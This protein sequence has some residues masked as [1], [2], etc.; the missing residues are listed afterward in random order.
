MAYDTVDKNVKPH[1][2]GG[3]ALVS[4]GKI[5][6][7]WGTSGYDD[8]KLGRWCWSRYQGSYGRHL[9]VVSVYRPC[10]STQRVSSIY[11]KQ[12]GYSLRTREGKC[13]RELFLRDLNNDVPSSK[14]M[15]DGIVL[16]GDFNQDVRS[17]EIE[18]WKQELGLEDKLLERV[19]NAGVQ[20][21]TYTGGH[22]PIDTILCTQGIEVTKSGYLAF[23]EGVGDHRHIY[24]CYNRVYFGCEFANTTVNGGEKT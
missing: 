17:K 11:M 2:A 16:M 13:P 4:T 5:S 10:L 7:T 12:Y 1:Q 9:R 15:G 19:A 24:R 3:A 20:L 6:H 22:A 21:N 18:D 23:G 14:G 8:H